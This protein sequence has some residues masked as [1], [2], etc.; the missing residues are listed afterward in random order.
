MPTCYCKK[1][2]DGYKFGEYFP[3][4]RCGEKY[5]YTIVPY[6]DVVG[7]KVPYQYWVVYNKDGD[8]GEQGYR[9]YRNK[10][11]ERLCYYLFSEYFHS[12][13]KVKLEKLKKINDEM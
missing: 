8:L 1:S 12:D 4:F 3:M 5:E 10:K 6:K 2:L 7:E 13:R 11:D 9:F